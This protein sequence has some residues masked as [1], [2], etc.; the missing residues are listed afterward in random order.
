[1]GLRTFL[2]TR[3]GWKICAEASNGREAVE[4]AKHTK[5]DVA[6]LDIGMPG[7]NGIEATRL[8][9]KVSPE[10]EILILSAHGSEKLAREVVEAGARG[11]LVKDDADENIF[12]AVEAL[13]RHRSYFPPKVTEWIAREGLSDGAR[14]PKRNLTPREREIMRPLAE[15]KTNK[16][17]AALFSI[18]AKT[19]E[20]H[21]A[22]IMMKL[23]LHSIA[24]LVQYA[25]RNHIIAG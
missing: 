6:I 25:I 7:L 24:E 2:E 21:R 14:K 23:N 17:V 4:T 18:S 22:N 13:G 9:R 1:M 19:V 11:Y 16:E 20:T 3:S 8:I 10:T 5:P 15:G 12:A